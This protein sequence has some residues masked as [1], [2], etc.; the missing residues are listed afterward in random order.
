MKY[1]VGMYGGSFNPLHLGHVDCIIRA[2]NQCEELFVVISAATR[3]KE[4]DVRIRY[5]WIYS[6]T[7]HIGNVRIL[8]LEDN[9]ESKAAYSEEEALE[10]CKKVR[11]MIGKPIDV[12]FC[13]S[14]YDENS[15]WN[16]GYPGSRFVVFERNGISS[17]E[18]RKNPYA[19]WDWLPDVVKAYYTKKVLLIGGESTGKSTLTINLANRFATNYIEEAG[20]DISMRSGDEMLMLPEDFTEI[21]LSH[22]LNEI[23]AAEKSN[24]VLFVDTDA[25]ITQFFIH[26]INEDENRDNIIL[27]DA[28]DRLNTY[29]L[30]LFLEPDVPFV[31]DG[32]RS[33]TICRERT[34][35]SRQIEDIFSAH[36]K[37]FRVISGDYDSRY[38]QAVS[39][40]RE[41]LNL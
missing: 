17:T 30:I 21:L 29:D 9:A 3:R 16:K 1:K 25:L 14:D 22:K 36:Q 20:R 13:G 5:R 11:R 10:D 35:Y 37:N 8:T 27:S 19:H 32:S 31:N 12:V 28:I 6:L 23:R 7:K 26:F 33:E 15:F 24:K 41:L 38:T 2:A 18:I 34:K 4:I 39:L 40:V